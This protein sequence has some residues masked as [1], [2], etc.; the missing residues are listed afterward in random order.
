MKASRRDFLILALD[1]FIASQ[2]SKT[3]IFK[4]KK[5]LEFENLPASEKRTA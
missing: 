4:K 5:C 2:R 3:S 1:F